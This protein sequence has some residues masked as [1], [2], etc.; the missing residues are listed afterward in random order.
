MTTVYIALP[1]VIISAGLQFLVSQLD[2]A[3]LTLAVFLLNWYVAFG[4]WV[5]FY[6]KRVPSQQRIDAIDMKGA[7]RNLYYCLWW[8][9]YLSRKG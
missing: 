2:M 6:F 7:L 5:V 9:W 8:P 4:A 1:Y 3:W